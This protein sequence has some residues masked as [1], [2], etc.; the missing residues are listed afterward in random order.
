MLS[1][2]MFS[3]CLGWKLRF[4]CV[5][6]IPSQVQS[7]TCWQKA[8][9]SVIRIP[10]L[11]TALLPSFPSSHTGLGSDASFHFYPTEIMQEY[12]W[13][14]MSPVRN[15]DENKGTEGVPGKP[16]DDWEEKRANAVAQEFWLF[17]L[18]VYGLTEEWLPR[19]YS[20]TT[21]REA[22]WV[23]PF[24]APQPDIYNLQMSHSD[25]FSMRLIKISRNELKRG[26]KL[27]HL[28]KLNVT[29]ISQH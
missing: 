3:Y 1:S 23:W 12:N 4:T 7:L 5:A 21:K 24:A 18:N 17:P 19:F 28:A 16:V 10:C 27:L 26:C 8:Q 22:P 11:I 9:V 14:G 29:P 15:A 25:D 20:T 2:E 6:K 13:E